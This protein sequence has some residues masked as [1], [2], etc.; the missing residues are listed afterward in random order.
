MG[1]SESFIEELSSTKKGKKIGPEYESA[2]K[3]IRKLWKDYMKIE[4]ATHFDID[5]N[6]IELLHCNIEQAG[7]FNNKPEF[8][9]KTQ[10]TVNAWLKTAGNNYIL[11]VGK[12]V[13][14]DVSLTPEQ[15]ERQVDIYM[16]Y[17]RTSQYNVTIPVPAGFSVEGMDKLNTKVDN[18]TGSFVSTA[19]L[20]SGKIILHVAQTF[21]HAFEKA[22][23]WQELLDIIDA[24]TSFENAKIL[25]RKE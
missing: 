22:N 2:F 14:P 12:M 1:I 9:Y 3:E 13:M 10:F 21:N 23:K 6:S 17:A 4:V 16:P 18:T 8:I 25:L 5:T 11:E 20:D 15:R 24:A 7:I 19:S